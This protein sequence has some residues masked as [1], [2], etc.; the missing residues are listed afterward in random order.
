MMNEI[1]EGEINEMLEVYMY[2]MI[3]K[4]NEEQLHDNHISNVFSRV[5]QY[6]MRFNSEKCTFRVKARKFLEFI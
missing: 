4:S 5:L 3:D 6:N 1:F 2:D